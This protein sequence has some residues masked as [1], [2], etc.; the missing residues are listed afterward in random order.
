M[1]NGY[2]NKVR[3]QGGQPGGSG[4]DW[5]KDDQGCYKVLG[6][7]GGQV[8]H[9]SESSSESYWWTVGKKRVKESWAQGEWLHQLQAYIQLPPSCR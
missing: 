4:G 9:S 5:E 2:K 8:L 1:E 6:G 7:K 3:K